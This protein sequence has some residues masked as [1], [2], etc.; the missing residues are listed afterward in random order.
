M[1]APGF[2]FRCYLGM[3]YFHE[4]GI[5]RIELSR[6]EILEKDERSLLE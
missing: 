6:R 5:E 2:G 1:M 4:R 3:R